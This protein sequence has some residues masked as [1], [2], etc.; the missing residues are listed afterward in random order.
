MKGE[1]ER[2]R[3]NFPV[4]KQIVNVMKT[5]VQLK[6]AAGCICN[7]PIDNGLAVLRGIYGVHVNVG[8]GE[9]T[10]EHTDEVTRREIV[11]RL[12]E[13]GYEERKENF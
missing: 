11:D 5:I 10:V 2:E 3:N 1:K 12:R 9:V 7:H 8:G 13:M 4:E 6:E